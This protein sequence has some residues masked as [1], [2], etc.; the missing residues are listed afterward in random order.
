MTGHFKIITLPSVAD[1][2]GQLTVLDNVLPFDVLRAFWITD[3][4]GQ[5]R[6]GH[7]HH[8]TRQA[9]IAMAGSVDVFMDDGAV[10]EVVRLTKPNQCLL[11]EPKDWHTMTFGPSAILLV[12]AS[13][14]YDRADYID[15]PYTPRP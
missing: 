14:H 1:P 13:H 2:R 12:L 3:A 5:T 15:E 8:Q 9:L 4:D 6:G 11:G 10:N 7:R